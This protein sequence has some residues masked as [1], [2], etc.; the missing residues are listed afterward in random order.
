[1]FRTIFS[2]IKAQALLYLQTNHVSHRDIKPENLLLA[3]NDQIQLCDFG[4]AI[5]YKNDAFRKTLCGTPEYVPPEM[6]ATSR[7]KSSSSSKSLSSSILGMTRA[8]SIHKKEISHYNTTFVDIW[9]L[10]VLSYEMVNGRTMFYIKTGTN[11]GKGREKVFAKIRSFHEDL[12]D[13]T[14]TQREINERVSGASFAHFVKNL[15]RIN[16][17]KRMKMN[18]V[19]NHA[20]FH[21]HDLVTKKHDGKKTSS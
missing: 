6:L 18:D 17:E 4:W 9:A 12:F 8:A 11:T 2:Q 10:G 16:P 19:L 13:W 21:E 20:W 3:S 5:Y 14:T 15:M 7:S 1:M